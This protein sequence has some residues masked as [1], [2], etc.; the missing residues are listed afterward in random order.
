VRIVWIL[1]GNGVEGVAMT[2]RVSDKCVMIIVWR[3]WDNSVKGVW[4]W[5]VIL[6]WRMCCNGVEGGANGESEW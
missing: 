4:Y 3:A 6:V 1:S 2:L 5:C